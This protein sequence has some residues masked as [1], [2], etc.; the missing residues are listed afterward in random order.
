MALESGEKTIFDY[1][2]EGRD[3]QIHKEELLLSFIYSGSL[4]NIERLLKD[5]VPVD[6]HDE[7]FTSK[8]NFRSFTFVL[9]SM[10]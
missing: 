10:E 8:P 5:H 6:T 7:V 1:A 9:Y 4:E 3:F 2:T